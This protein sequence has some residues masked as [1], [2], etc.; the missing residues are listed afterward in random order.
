MDQ[1]ASLPSW[2]M[3]GNGADPAAVLQRSPARPG[4]SPNSKGGVKRGRR[5]RGRG[6][7]GGRGR[8]SGSPQGSRRR[9]GIRTNG[10][11]NTSPGK[12]KRLTDLTTGMQETILPQSKMELEAPLPESEAVESNKIVIED[13]DHFLSELRAYLKDWVHGSLSGPLDSDLAKVTTY[14]TQ[15]CEDNLEA[16]FVVLQGFRRLLVNLGIPE[17][18]TA[19]NSLL[20]TVQ[21]CIRV[22]YSGTLPVENIDHS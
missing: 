15:L 21:N 19:F 10:A 5:G 1:I 4:R 9:Q 2:D 13:L 18:F 8:G 11:L 3:I 14:F 12:Q 17:W 22:N 16:V 7:G 6:G 20:A